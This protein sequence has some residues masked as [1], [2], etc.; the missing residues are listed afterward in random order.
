MAPLSPASGVSV[1]LTVEKCLEI[2]PLA[3][4]A[5]VGGRAGLAT[6]QVR[7]MTVIEGPVDDFVSPGDFVLT[8]GL[9]YGAERLHELAADVADAEAAALV[10]AVGDASPVAAV[11]EDVRALADK[12]A[13]PVVELAWEIR[14]ADVLR[15]LTD[16]LLSARYA[17][18]LDADDQL[19]GGFADALLAREGL[20]AIAAACEAIVDRPVLILDAGLAVSAHG[21][22]AGERLGEEALA[23]QPAA[24]HALEPEALSGFCQRRN[25]DDIR[26]CD[27][28][29]RVGLPA[30]LSAAAV[31]QGDTLGYVHACGDGEPHEPLIVERHALGH[32]AVAVAIEML[33]RRAVAEAEARARGDFLWELAD[34]ASAAEADLATKAVLLGYEVARPYRVMLVEAETAR[35]DALDELARQLRRQGALAGLQASRRADRVLVLVPADAPPP[36]APASLAREAE[37]RMT[38]GAC[39]WA[40]AEGEFLL[41]DIADGV[42]GAERALRVGRALHGPGA[43]ADAGELGPFLMLD[44]IAGDEAAQRTAAAVLAPLEAYDAETSRGLVETLETFLRE[45]GN[46]T[47]AAR[48]LFLN[49]HSLMY[50]LR[51]IEALTGRSLDRHDD[52]FILE[53]S[54]RLRRML[55]A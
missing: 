3:D 21:P 2:A 6:R 1:G 30:G 26:W 17:A 48:A 43:V 37:A 10:V 51:K 53:L 39:S 15:A 34:G 42:A 8:T 5:V 35:D 28:V 44:G 40:V 54:V 16:R 12:R 45:N 29:E 22:L 47:Q 31:A 27:T 18:A 7:W 11:P 46:T 13:M 19:P 4:A 49:R 36:L 55:P 24:A 23:A 14:F 32:A 20:D 41:P 25:G 9:G 52:R 33:R 50:R 38:P